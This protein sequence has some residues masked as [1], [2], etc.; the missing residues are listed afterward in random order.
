MH[1]YKLYFKGDSESRKIK[2]L[3]KDHHLRG[4]WG[5]DNDGYYLFT[6]SEEDLMIKDLESYG[7]S[8]VK[9]IGPVTD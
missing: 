9:D 1:V 3:A 2:E 8:E 7:V 5:T 4:Y 6:R